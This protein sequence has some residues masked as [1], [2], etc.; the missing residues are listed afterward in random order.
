MADIPLGIKECIDLSTKNENICTLFN[1]LRV[2]EEVG[3]ASAPQ[4]VKVMTDHGEVFEIDRFCPH[5]GADLSD[6][7]MLSLLL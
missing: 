7:P 3:L 4:R 6:V 5:K 1:D 2:V